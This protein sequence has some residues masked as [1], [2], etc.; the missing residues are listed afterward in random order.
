MNKQVMSLGCCDV[1]K[2]NL[3]R[4]FEPKIAL[5]LIVIIALIFRV[6]TLRYKYLFGYDPYFHLAYIEESLKAGHW[7]NFYPLA[8][9]PWGQLFDKTWHPLGFYATPVYV[10]KL[11]KVFGVS[12]YNAFRITPAIFGVLTIVFFYLAMLNLYGKKRLSSP[13]FSC[14]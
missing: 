13:R 5:P 14:R 2:F 11:L 9:A 12:L 7:I 10:W 3:E 1:K 6:V 8:S 4:V